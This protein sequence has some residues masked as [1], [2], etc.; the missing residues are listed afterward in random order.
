MKQMTS[1]EFYS[2]LKLSEYGRQY[3]DF[4]EKIQSKK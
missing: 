3:L 4:I 2:N 1:E